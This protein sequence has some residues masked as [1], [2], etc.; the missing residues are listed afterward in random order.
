VVEHLPE[1]LLQEV[2]ATVFCEIELQ[3]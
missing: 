3:P 1:D 2:I